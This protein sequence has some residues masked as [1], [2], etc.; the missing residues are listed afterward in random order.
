MDFRGFRRLGCKQYLKS[1]GSLVL[2]A[3]LGPKLSPYAYDQQVRGD[4]AMWPCF[5]H[6]F[7]TDRLG[8]DLLVRCMIGSRISLLV[9][10][11]SAVIVMI[12]GSIYGSISGLAGG[13]TI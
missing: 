3:F 6:P 7:G 10:L 1:F 8:R 12:I 13:A 2:F 11:I 4:E 5:K 9:G